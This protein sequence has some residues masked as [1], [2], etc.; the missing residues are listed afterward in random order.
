VEVLVR[1]RLTRRSFALGA[2]AIVAGPRGAR[3]EGDGVTADTIT[4]GMEGLSN[5][6]SNEEENLGF[7][8]AFA[9]ASERGVHGRRIAIKAYPRSGGAATDEA[10]ANARRLVEQDGVFALINFGG[11]VA[12]PMRAYAQERRVPYLFPHTALISSAGARYVF[13]SFPSYGGEAAIMFPYLARER[14]LR[15]IGIVHDANVYGQFFLERLREHA[16]PAGYAVAGVSTRDPQDLKAELRALIDAGADAVVMALYPAQA[17]TL[18]KAKAELGWSGRMISVGPLTDE[19]YLNVPG[20][21]A[22][23]TLGFCYYPDPDRSD[24]PGV[25][26]YRAMM[27]QREPGRPLNRYTL[28]GYTF[29]RLVVAGLEGAGRELTRESFIDAMERIRD[30][31]SGGV[32]PPVTLAPDNHHAQ[33]AG[34]LCELR[35]SRFQPLSEWVAP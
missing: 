30:W 34:F 15:H 35:Q 31:D 16:G 24:A 4:F 26:R 2:A 3:A 17:G 23:G 9:E 27:A 1:L 20:G 5:S 29:G 28:Y 19:Q 12:I 6:F 22:E 13:T 10:M 18:M 21:H 25:A 8:L 11:P 7:R 14:G 33:R 32:M